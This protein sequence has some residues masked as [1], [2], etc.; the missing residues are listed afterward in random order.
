M[1][2]EFYQAKEKNIHGGRQVVTEHEIRSQAP[3]W[4]VSEATDADQH[5]HNLR[6]WQQEYDQLSAGRFYGRIDEVAVPSLQVFREY[7][8]QSLHQHCNVWPDSVWLGFASAPQGSE[9]VCRINGQSVSA[10]EL[11]CRPG[12]CDFEL[13]TP[14]DFHIYGIVVSQRLLMDTADVQ[15][16]EIRDGMWSEP[17]RHWHNGK[18]Q[19]LRHIMGRM[20]AGNAG[21]P[22]VIHQDML[23]GSVLEVLG[24]GEARSTLQNTTFARRKAVVERVQEYLAAHPGESITITDLCRLTHVSR[25]TLQYSFE[26]VLG[27][28]PLKYLRLSRLNNM[29]RAL[30][31]GLGE[32]ETIASKSS[33]WGFWHAGQFAHDYRQLFGETPSQTL[34]RAHAG[35]RNNGIADLN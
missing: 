4:C 33:E 2:Y 32:D 21:R 28:S 1:I 13:L 18:L 20:F 5:A 35:A 25:R 7:T 14:D 3:R 19:M 9:D 15:G 26:T 22:G 23:L 16:V 30:L 24:D 8:S 10:Q 17:R 29:R 31:E 27:L 34:N 6:D 12:N 11:M